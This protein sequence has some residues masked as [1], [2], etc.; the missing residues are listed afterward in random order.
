MMVTIV[1]IMLVLVSLYLHFRVNPILKDKMVADLVQKVQVVGRKSVESILEAN[2]SGAN[3]LLLG[4]R[5]DPSVEVA[6]ILLVDGS[7]LGLYSRIN[8]IHVPSIDISK[9]LIKTKNSLKIIEPTY[10]KDKIIG[11]LHVQYNSLAIATP[12]TDYVWFI[13]ALALLMLTLSFLLSNFFQAQLTRPIKMMVKH[14]ANMY[15][16]KKFDKRLESV[17]DDEIGKLIKGFNQIW[18][19]TQARE[20]ELTEK[21]KQLQKLV[22]VRSKQLFQKEH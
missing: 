19:A 12:K 3:K 8:D 18:D 2:N 15:E 5:Q 6:A 13:F 22:D 1:S 9:P 21:S 14:I 10:Y 11:Y 4:F 16:S 17:S 20:N 7:L